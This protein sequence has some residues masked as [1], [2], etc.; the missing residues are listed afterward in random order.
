[1]TVPAETFVTP[2][3]RAGA[4]W[5]VPRL[6]AGDL[7]GEPRTATDRDHGHDSR[8]RPGRTGDP[9]SRG[10]RPGSGEVGIE[11]AGGAV[12]A[13]VRAR[14]AR[15]RRMA[16]ERAGG[17]PSAWPGVVEAAAFSGGGSAW[18]STWSAAPRRC[19]PRPRARRA[20]VGLAPWLC[21]RARGAAG[22]GGAGRARPVLMGQFL[23]VVLAVGRLVATPSAAPS[24]SSSLAAVVGIGLLVPSV[25][26]ATT[27]RHDRR[28]TSS[29]TVRSRPSAQDPTTRGTAV[30]VDAPGARGPHHGRGAR[31]VRVQHQQPPT[32]GSGAGTRAP[33]RPRRRRRGSSRRTAARCGPDGASRSSIRSGCGSRRRRGR[34]RRARAHG[35]APASARR[36][37]RPVLP[38]TARRPRPPRRGTTVRADQPGGPRRPGAPS[39]PSRTTV[40]VVS[41]GAR[42]AATRHRWRGRS[43]DRPAPGGARRA[44]HRAG[45]S[46][47]RPPAPTGPAPPTACRAAEPG[48][49]PD[50]AAPPGTARRRRARG[51]PHVPGLAVARPG[52]TGTPASGRPTGSGGSRAPAGRAN[53]RGQARRGGPERATAASGDRAAGRG[54]RAR[55]EPL[56][57]GAPREGGQ[58][59]EGRP[60]DVVEH[61]QRA[62]SRPAA[63]PASRRTRRATRRRRRRG[64][65]SP[66]ASARRG[67]QR[68]R[69][70]DGVHRPALGEGG[71]RHGGQR[72]RAA[73]ARSA[74]DE[75]VPGVGVPAD[76]AAGEL[77]GQVGERERKAGP[78]RDVLD[79]DHVRQRRQPGLRG[80]RA[81]GGGRRDRRDPRRRPVLVGRASPPAAHV[82]AAPAS[83]TGADRRTEAS[84]TC[85]GSGR[86]A[87][88]GEHGEPRPVDA[89]GVG[90]ADQ[91]G[92]LRRVGHPQHHP[93]RHVGPQVRRHRAGGPLRRQ[94]QVDAERAALRGEPGEAR[95]Q[96]GQLVGQHAE[97]VGHHQQPGRRDGGV[98]VPHVARAA[99]GE[100]PL[101]PAQLGGQPAQG[102]PGARGV[103]VGQVP[104]DVR[105]PRHRRRGRCRP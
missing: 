3:G 12:H 78:G 89:R 62:G 95:Q 18:S 47:R 73:R 98:E 70:P 101:A 7:R 5:Q 67:R 34:R 25:V 13:P 17:G 57:G 53:A 20:R 50:S 11:V 15:V 91:V 86:L 93:Q 1:M 16:E 40:A 55:L 43:V 76:R 39:A 35:P 4:A 66:P 81:A 45:P 38:R 32:R 79:P 51:A 69:Q 83:R 72:G 68:G 49:R 103:E 94:H 99:R 10:E 87:P 77:V 104:D 74:D 30:R 41:A 23:L 65:Q 75:Q 27:A 52:A 29:T 14:P 102:A 24:S 105:Q 8:P 48:R 19:P 84:A 88:R 96:V 100:D 61:Q 6:T 36:S 63:A 37:A 26:A 85:T 82:C 71:D 54:P 56:G 64:A 31:L 44:R 60:G 97:L 92:G 21:R 33:R 59:S 42:A 9:R 58:L 80:A 2:V 46:P 22:A 28:V 90:D